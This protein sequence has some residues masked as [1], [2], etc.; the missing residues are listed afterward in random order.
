MR[1]NHCGSTALSLYSDSA[2]KPIETGFL[3]D[4]LSRKSSYTE[5]FMDLSTE[6]SVSRNIEDTSEEGTHNGQVSGVLESKP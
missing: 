1:W 2:V 3:T 4:Q 6:D 5:Y